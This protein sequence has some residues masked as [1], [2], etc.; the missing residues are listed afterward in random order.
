MAWF[1]SSTF[2]S[3]TPHQSLQAFTR[4]CEDIVEIHNAGSWQSLSAA[5][6]DLGWKPPDGS[7]HERNHNGLDR[8]EYDV[9]G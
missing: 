5:E 6:C 8:V 4:N 7:G 1:N 9:S 2:E 3:R